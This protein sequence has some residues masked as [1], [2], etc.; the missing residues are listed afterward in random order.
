MT[1]HNNL[2][3]K[4]HAL[5]KTSAVYN[6]KTQ[7]TQNSILFLPFIFKNA[8]HHDETQHAVLVCFVIINRRY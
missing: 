2:Y 5:V 4:Q 6:D 3:S 8:I 7:Y 1:K